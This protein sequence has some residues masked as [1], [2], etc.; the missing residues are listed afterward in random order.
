VVR[1]ADH[2]FQV[3]VEGER[4][5]K[6]LERAAD[7]DPALVVVNTSSGRM[8]VGGWDERVVD[9]LFLVLAT[10]VWR[11][12]LRTSNSPETPARMTETLRRLAPVL[13]IETSRG[14]PHDSAERLFASFTLLQCA[15]SGAA[16]PL[17]RNLCGRAWGMWHATRR[18][19]G[20]ERRAVDAH[21][22]G[23][24]TFDEDEPPG[25]L[26]NGRDLS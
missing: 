23:N 13:V 17:W 6:K 19:R 3:V 21:C 11:T 9:Q 16:R 10:A 4:H 15:S 24:D 2:M 18:P 14:E 1:S 8:G 26:M 22:P 12:I 25:E 20:L 7:C 5:C